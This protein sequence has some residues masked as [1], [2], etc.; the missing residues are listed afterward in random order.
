VATPQSNRGARQ[1]RKVFYVFTVDKSRLEA[2]LALQRISSKILLN[3]FRFIEE[4]SRK[5]AAF[6]DPTYTPFYYHLGRQIEPKKMLIVGFGLGL[7]AGCFLKGCKTVD[8]ILA[9]EELSTEYFS[10]RREFDFKMGNPFDL[11]ESLRAH[12]WDLTLIDSEVNYDKLRNYLD[13]IWANTAHNGL[14]VMEHISGDSSTQKAF[15]DFCK[16]I[17]RE[18]FVFATRYGTGIVQK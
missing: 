7:S 6:Q 9:I 17:N 14:I 1:T 3:G 12:E 13:V 10:P 11:Q 15:F 5:T 4:S 18:P 8:G 2:D 16:I